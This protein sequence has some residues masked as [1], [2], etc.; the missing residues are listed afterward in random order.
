MAKNTTI[1]YNMLYTGL[2]LATTIIAP[3]KA[4]ADNPQNNISVM[5]MILKPPPSPPKGRVDYVLL[6]NIF[7]F[8]PVTQCLFISFRF[9]YRVRYQ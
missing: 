2:L 4:K 9:L 8:C 3:N 1:R 7:F 5:L 6:I